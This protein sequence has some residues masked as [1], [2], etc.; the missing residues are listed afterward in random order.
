M[1]QRGRFNE[2]LE[3]MEEADAESL[4]TLRI[5]Q[6]W[7]TILGMLKLRRELYR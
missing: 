5:Q 2:A 3:R 7:A 6:Y 1:A 4:R